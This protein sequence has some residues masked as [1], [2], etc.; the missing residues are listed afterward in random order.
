MASQGNKIC[1][2][3]GPCQNYQTT[4]EGIHYRMRRLLDREDVSA[5]SV[6]KELKREEKNAQHVLGLMHPHQDQESGPSMALRVQLVVQP[7]Q[8]IQDQ[9]QDPP[10]AGRGCDC[11]FTSEEGRFPSEGAFGVGRAGFWVMTASQ[12]TE[13]EGAGGRATHRH[14]RRPPHLQEPAQDFST[15]RVDRP[16]PPLMLHRYSDA[17]EEEIE[18]VE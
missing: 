1:R 12:E 3:C 10:E 13:P 16:T 15:A 4:L 11:R 8:T 5:P 18:R 17:E 2:P 6:L 9:V 14:G 7:D